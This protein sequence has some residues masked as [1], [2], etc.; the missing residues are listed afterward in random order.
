MKMIQIGILVGCLS[1]TSC[2]DFTFRQSIYLEP[3]GTA[4]WV[5]FVSD[6]FSDEDNTK[7]REDEIVAFLEKLNWGE[8]VVS[9]F[10]WEAGAEQVECHLIRDQIP[11]AYVVTGHFSNAELI[12][13]ALFD[14]E[15]KAQW[16]GFREPDGFG[17]HLSVGQNFFGDD[18]GNNSMEF[19]AVRGEVE[20]DGI[21]LEDSGPNPKLQLDEN[22]TF[23]NIT[24]HWVKNDR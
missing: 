1:M 4:N 5:V 11:L 23:H 19:V 24:F 13:E 8:E 10:L 7:K 6:V 20:I 16:A 3:D 15:E 9:E 22:R 18:D 17:I 21:A 2:L 14:D 12:F